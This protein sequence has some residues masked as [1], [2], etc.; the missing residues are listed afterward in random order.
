MGVGVSGV[1]GVAMATTSSGA[2]TRKTNSGSIT[3]RKEVLRAD[4]MQARFSTAA[5]HLLGSLTQRGSIRW[6]A[7]STAIHIAPRSTSAGM[8][9]AE[10]YVENASQGR[11]VHK[12]SVA[13]LVAKARN[14]ALMDV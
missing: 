10:G 4:G 11:Y 8:M 9:A 3:A 6:N 1:G 7:I 13:P 2:S 12:G 14:V 5:S